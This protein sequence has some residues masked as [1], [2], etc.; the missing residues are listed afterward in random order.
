MPARSGAEQNGSLLLVNPPVVS[1]GG[2]E[3]GASYLRLMIGNAP[4]SSYFS[5]PVEHLGLMS[6][7]AYAASQG[8]NVSV[9]NGIVDQHHHEDETLAAI[10]E[11]VKRDGPPLLIG[12]SSIL[13]F[14][15]NIWLAEECKRRW[16][17]VA[18]IFGHD[19]ATLNSQRILRQ[20]AAVDFLCIGEG[21]AVFTA[22]ALSL[23]NGRG[24]SG[25]AGLA[26]RESPGRI[27]VNT[28]R[29]MDLDALPWAARDELPKVQQLGFAGA[30]Y[31]SRGC[32]YS[33]TFCT[34]GQASVL[35]GKGAYR[36]RSIEGIVDEMEYLHRD[37]GC[38]FFNIADDL[39]LTKAES[40]KDRARRFAKALKDRKLG[41]RFMVDARVDSIER[42]VFSDLHEAGLCR[43]FVGVESG[44]REQ[45]AAYHKRYA[46]GKETIT[47][48]LAILID[49]GLDVVPGIIAFH[50]AVTPGELREILRIMEFVN[51]KAS[52]MLVS[53]VI[54]FPGTVICEEFRRAGYLVEDWP[55]G[56]WNFQDAG[57]EKMY[58]CVQDHLQSHPAESFAD[59]AAFFRRCLDEWETRITAARAEPALQA[60]AGT[61]P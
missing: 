8:L 4:P 34:T 18:T 7:K 32:P 17:K 58:R 55:L 3:A 57:S 59:T 12:F 15:Q 50:P 39:F 53:P 2:H 13:G 19:F 44:S 40:S 27:H 24:E 45:L 35:L 28:P 46:L 25:I 23:Q 22:L 51:F 5:I 48:R 36:T 56:L 11:V 6:I 38:D 47:D 54:A 30:V 1:G 42:D 26:W 29:L 21:E 9:V 49:L 61:K 43:V 41:V 60:G 14:E 31:A 52:N 20:Y 16:P 37:F 33:C 10:E